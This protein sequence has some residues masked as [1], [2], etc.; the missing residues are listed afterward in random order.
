[1]RERGHAGFVESATLD[2]SFHRA[3]F[4]AR[5]VRPCLFRH[6]WIHHVR[7]RFRVGQQRRRFLKRRERASE[8]A[9]RL[10]DTGEGGQPGDAPARVSELL[11]QLDP[12]TAS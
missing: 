3:K 4:A 1:M 8:I 6:D 2:P 10:K 5:Q 11:A 12:D 7:H 9:A